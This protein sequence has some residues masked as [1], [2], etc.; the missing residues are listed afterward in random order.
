MNTEDALAAIGDEKMPRERE[1]Q[2]EDRRGRKREMGDCQGI[3]GNKRIDDKNPRMVKFTPL[4]MP[5]DKIL[6]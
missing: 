2:G 3:D 4:V 1:R 6:M 5:V